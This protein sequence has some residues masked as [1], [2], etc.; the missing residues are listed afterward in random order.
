MTESEAIKRALELLNRT[1]IVTLGTFGSTSRGTPDNAPAV[2]DFVNMR[3]MMKL[4][5]HGLE[6]IW[7][8]TNTSSQKINELHRDPS[9]SIYLSDNREYRGLLLQGAI[10]IRTDSESRR[11]VWRI[12]FEKYYPGG[13]DDPDHTVLV[14]K[15]KSGKYYEGLAKLAFE[16]GGRA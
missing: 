14:F 15:A 2:A 4:D 6:D 13:V 7:M 16:I 11:S 8:S 3:S 5:N 10:E 1:V 9:A 12:G